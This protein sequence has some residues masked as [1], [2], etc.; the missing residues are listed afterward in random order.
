[1]RNIKRPEVLT[2]VTYVKGWVSV[3]FLHELIESKLQFVWLIEFIHSTL[4]FVYFA[5][6]T[7]DMAEWVPSPA[8]L[9]PAPREGPDHVISPRGRDGRDSPPPPP[10]SS[11]LTW[12]TDGA[13]DRRSAVG[14]SNSNRWLEKVRKEQNTCLRKPTVFGRHKVAIDDPV[15]IGRRIDMGK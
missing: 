8:P 10:Q 6:V 4:Y 15:S 7:G 13:E 14:W 5:H 3:V 12:R 11:G 9:A 1:M 2:H